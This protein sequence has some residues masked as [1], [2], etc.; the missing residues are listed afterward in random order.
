MKLTRTILINL[1]LND[2]LL[3]LNFILMSRKLQCRSRIQILSLNICVSPT[4]QCYHE[5]KFAQ[6]V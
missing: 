5:T 4:Q 2:Y 3:S 6:H 1:I